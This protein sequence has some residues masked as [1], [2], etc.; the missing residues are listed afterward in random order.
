LRKCSSSRKPEKG[1]IKID[2]QNEAQEQNEEF[3]LD[4]VIKHPEKRYGI[5]KADQIEILTL[6]VKDGLKWSKKSMA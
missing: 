3:A 2:R 1:K 4:H 6:K 5:I